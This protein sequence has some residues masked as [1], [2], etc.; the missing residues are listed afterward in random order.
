MLVV[1]W[2]VGFVPPLQV[3]KFGSEA[4]G[5][6]LF[7]FITDIIQVEVKQWHGNGQVDARVTF[8]FDKAK[9]RSED[10]AMVVNVEKVRTFFSFSFISLSFVFLIPSCLPV[11]LNCG[12][13]HDES[14]VRFFVL[15]VYNIIAFHY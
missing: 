14:E 1:E 10:A 7:R 13:I 5:E 2:K 15:L 4:S 8:L 9:D 11:R 6:E 3:Q 12:N